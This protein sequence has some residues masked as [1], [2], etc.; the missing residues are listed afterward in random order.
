MYHDAP[1]CTGR[2]W[3]SEVTGFSSGE[4][5]NRDNHLRRSSVFSGSPWKVAVER[6]MRI[7]LPYAAGSFPVLPMNYTPQSR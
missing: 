6:V 7:E 3:F 5:L 1:F 4:K 2:Q